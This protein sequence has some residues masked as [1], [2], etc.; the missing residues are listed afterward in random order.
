[1]IALVVLKMR[2]HIQ[3]MDQPT[4]DLIRP[5]ILQY[6]GDTDDVAFVGATRKLL[7]AGDQTF[8]ALHNSEP[9]NPAKT[10]FPVPYE[11][12]FLTAHLDTLGLFPLEIQ[13]RLLRVGSDLRGF[14]ERVA[15]IQVAINRTWDSS[16]ST[17]NRQQ[18]AD[19]LASGIKNLATTAEGLVKAINR[20]LDASGRPLWK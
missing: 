7:E 3:V 13:R 11:A 15:F 2:A 18:N 9:P 17:I 4:L 19:N 16:L 8:I 20:L 1:M 10:P 14:N 12:P 6:T 5:I